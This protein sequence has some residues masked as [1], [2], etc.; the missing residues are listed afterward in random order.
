LDNG[1]SAARHALAFAGLFVTGIAAWT[2]IYFALLIWAIAAGG[3]LGSPVVYPI[4][5]GLI[6]LFVAGGGLLLLMPSTVVG[7][8]VC[9]GC[10][11]PCFMGIPIAF[12]AL[13]L[14]SI[15]IGAG[16]SLI[17]L[18]EGYSIIQTGGMVVTLVALPLG[19][20]WWAAEFPTV[21]WE[22]WR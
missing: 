12:G 5:L 9:R 6:A 16:L 22:L 14:L 11:L 19:L 13:C 2:V 15:L 3:G 7:E 21:V 1:F 8:L 4:G 18:W 20:Y 17:Q 10:S